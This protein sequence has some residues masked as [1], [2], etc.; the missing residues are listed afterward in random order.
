MTTSALTQRRPWLAAA[1]GIAA[2]LASA[3]LPTSAQAHDSRIVAGVAGGF[4]GGMNV[5]SALAPRPAYYAPAYSAAPSPVY[6]YPPVPQCY[7]TLGAP[8]WDPNMGSYRRPM[9]RVCN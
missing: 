1:V 2:A 5:G 4:A 3:T 8:V 7:W 9:I 6:Y